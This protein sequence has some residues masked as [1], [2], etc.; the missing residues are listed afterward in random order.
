M[1][2]AFATS[3]AKPVVALRCLVFSWVYV[4]GAL[5]LV[6]ALK[7]TL[8]V[9]SC[10]ANSLLLSR[11]KGSLQSIAFPCLKNINS[12]PGTAY[13]LVYALY[14]I[15]IEYVWTRSAVQCLRNCTGFSA[16]AVCK[17]ILKF[18]YLDVTYVTTNIYI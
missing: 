16:C 1:G 3:V 15:R 4:R 13:I 18:V 12:L 14:F 9:Y 5:Y 2:R 11:S 6:W 17:T 10:Q 7:F 8:F